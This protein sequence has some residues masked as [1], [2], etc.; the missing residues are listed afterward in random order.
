MSDEL[1]I[2]IPTPDISISREEIEKKVND[3]LNE[4]VNNYESVLSAIHLPKD[5]TG[6]VTVYDLKYEVTYEFDNGKLQAVSVSYPDK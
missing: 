1:T 6:T 3:K 4:A 2:T 5:L